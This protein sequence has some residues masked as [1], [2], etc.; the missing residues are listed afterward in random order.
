MRGILCGFGRPLFLSLLNELKSLEGS[1]YL[2][3]TY[4]GLKEVLIAALGPSY[5]P[6][7]YMS[8]GI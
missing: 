1:M 3:S 7:G 8:A 6:Y 4:L 5:I 2:Y